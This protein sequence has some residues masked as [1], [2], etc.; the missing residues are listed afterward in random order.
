MLISALRYS[1]INAKLHSLKS[2]LLQQS[3]YKNLIH[4]QGIKGFV[5]YSDSQSISD[6]NH[7]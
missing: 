1:Y 7:P 3:D 2:M 4:L 5:E 6:R